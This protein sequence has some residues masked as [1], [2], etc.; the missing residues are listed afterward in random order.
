MFQSKLYV[1]TRNFDEGSLKGHQSKEESL[2]VVKL[3]D[4]EVQAWEEESE[5]ILRKLQCSV[6]DGLVVKDC[7]FKGKQH[8][9]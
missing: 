4:K 5:F 8:C 7:N 3:L 6:S 1:G 9:Y 2:E